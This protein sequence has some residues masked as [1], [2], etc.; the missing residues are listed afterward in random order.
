[1]IKRHE[2]KLQ[3]IELIKMFSCG[4][5]LDCI[6]EIDIINDVI[7]SS[8]VFVSFIVEIESHFNIEILDDF[9]DANFFRKINDIVD[10]VY[11]MINKDD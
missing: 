11:K 2:I 3:V 5:N 8:I 10:I 7:Q 1:M 9:L 6:D 4:L